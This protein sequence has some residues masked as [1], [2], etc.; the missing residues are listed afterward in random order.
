MTGPAAGSFRVGSL[1]KLFRTT[2]FRLSLVYLAVF[3]LFGL[4]AIAYLTWQAERLLREQLQATVEADVEGLIDQYA[5]GGIRGLTQRPAA[6]LPSAGRQSLPRDQLRRPAVGR[7]RAQRARL[8]AGRGAMGRDGLRVAQRQRRLRQ[9]GAHQR[10]D[11]AERVPP[12]RRPRPQADRRGAPDHLARLVLDDAG[13][14]LPLAPGE[15][16]RQ[17]PRVAP[18]RRHGGDEPRHHERRHDGASAGGRNQ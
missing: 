4:G 6:S 8:R 17:P 5:S 3:I 7:Q 11:P 10:H 18:G 16:L 14:R 15:P 9:D 2:A 12:S 13:L 1:L